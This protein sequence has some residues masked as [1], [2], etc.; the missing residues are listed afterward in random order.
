M[1]ITS[2]VNQYTETGAYHPGV[3]FD[4]DIA[5]TVHA[6]LREKF[7]LQKEPPKSSA[8]DTP[9]QISTPSTEGINNVS[10]F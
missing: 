3:T 2:A 5:D 6:I 10:M 8:P 7:T 9:T 1:R 4:P